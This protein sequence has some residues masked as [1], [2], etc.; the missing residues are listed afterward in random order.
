[1]AMSSVVNDSAGCCDTIIAKRRRMAT[2]F[3]CQSAPKV[4]AKTVK[5]VDLGSQLPS[6]AVNRNPRSSQFPSDLRDLN[7]VIEE[8]TRRPTFLTLRA[9]QQDV[10]GPVAQTATLPADPLAMAEM[11]SFHQAL[12]AYSSQLSSTRKNQLFPFTQSAYQ[13]EYG[14]PTLHRA[15]DAPTHAVWSQNT[16]TVAGPNRSAFR[17]VPRQNDRLSYGH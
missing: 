1:M 8:Q 6:D 10:R 9:R 4:R 15:A 11:S 13:K 17:Q 5:Q 12:D 14:L 3:R 7:Q 2:T 16:S